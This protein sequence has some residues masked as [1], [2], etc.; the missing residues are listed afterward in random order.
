[1]LWLDVVLHTYLPLERMV[2]L[3]APLGLGPAPAAG[4][5]VMFWQCEPTQAL[6]SHIPA[7]E[8]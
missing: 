1:M 6:L 2:A 7:W 8:P 4:V 5:A 3:P